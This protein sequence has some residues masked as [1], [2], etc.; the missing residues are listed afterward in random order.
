MTAQLTTDQLTLLRGGGYEGSAY[1]VAG[2]QAVIFAA[3]V[4]GTPAASDFAQITYDTVTVGAY[5]DI[6]VDQDI[7]I[8]R[9]G[10]VRDS[11]FY[12]R[13]R[14]TPTSSI[15]YINETSA[16]IADNDYIHVVDSYPLV[17]RQRYRTFVDWDKAYEPLPPIESNVPSASVVL[18]TAATAEFSFASV[19]QA[20]EKGATVTGVLWDIPNAT[21]TTGSTSTANITIEVDTPYN[22]WGHLTLTDSEG[23]TVSL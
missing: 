22:Q 2:P 14:K 16:A 8:S 13:I 6:R 4:N 5:T 3:R 10:N 9:T 17:I 15:L 1:L 21:Y 23:S 7:R 11:F 18:T 20:L 19:G 12:G